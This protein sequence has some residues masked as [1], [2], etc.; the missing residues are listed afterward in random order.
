MPKIGFGLMRLPEKDGAID[1]EQV[2]KMADAYMEAGFNYFDTA[3]VYHGGNSEKVVKEAIVKRFPRESFTIA[4]KLPAWFLHSFE[5][6]DKVFEEQLDRCGVDYFDYYLLHSLEDGNNYDTYEKYDCFNWGI[7]KRDEGRIKHFGFSFHGTPELLVQVLDKHPEIEFVQIQLNYADWDNKIVHSGELYEILRD[8]NIPMII[9][10][11]AKG[12]KLANLDD[13]CAEILKAI[14]PDKS[15]ASW[16]FR[17]VGSL[18]GI[19]TILSGMSTPEQMEDNINTFKDFEPLS[20]E[21]LAAIDKVKEIMNRVELAGCTSCKYCV[22]GC[23]MGIPI[24]DV[25]SAVNTRRKFPGDMRPQFFYNG[26]VD[27]YSH[28]S[29]CIACGQCEGV[30]PQHLP[31][32]DLMKEAVERF[33]GEA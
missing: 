22:E 23:P 30:C 20:E 25:I 3:Y 12:G 7:K 1:I 18:P 14:R 27:R 32:I 29:D 8:R 17:Y 33:E 19:A 13:E 9:M 21:E 6:R 31:I 24:P 28:A 26:L 5:D 16:A 2:S 11:P 4:T 15:I 10:E